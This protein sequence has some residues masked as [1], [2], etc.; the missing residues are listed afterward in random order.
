MKSIYKCIFLRLAVILDA[1]TNSKTKVG[2]ETKRERMKN[3][4]RMYNSKSDRLI[5][6]FTGV[7]LI[8]VKIVMGSRLN[9]RFFKPDPRE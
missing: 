3:K 7:F 5:M 4:N 1:V 6:R 9:A 8:L 2:T